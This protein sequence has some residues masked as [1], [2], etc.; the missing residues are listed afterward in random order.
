M[1]VLFAAPC[2]KLPNIR[3]GF[4]RRRGMRHGI[5]ASFSCRRGY[6]LVGSSRTTCN[7]GT[8]SAAIPKC[9]GKLHNS[10]YVKE[11]GIRYKTQS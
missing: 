9:L 3:N 7:N 1:I 8:W 5:R 4:T 2:Q 11:S 6:K 10:T